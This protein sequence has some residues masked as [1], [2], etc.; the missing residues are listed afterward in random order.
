MQ[1]QY[2]ETFY[3][4]IDLQLPETVVVNSHTRVVTYTH[5]SDQ[6]RLTLGLT[7]FSRAERQVTQTSQ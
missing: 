7:N 4:T 6:V 2:M 3:L 1:P 5:W